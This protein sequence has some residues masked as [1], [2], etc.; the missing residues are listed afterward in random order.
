MAFPSGTV[1]GVDVSHYQ[2]VVDWPTL[3]TTGEAFAFAKA[4]EG[5]SIPDLYFADNW[6]AMRAAGILRGAYH[7]FHPA[8][9][10]ADQVSFFLDRLQNANGGSTQLAPGDLP[11]ALDLEVSDGVA[12]ADIIAGAGAWLVAIEAQTGRKPIV[13]TY[14]DFWKTTL[15]NPQ[16]LAGYPLWISQLNVNSPSIPGGWGNWIF[17]QFAKQPVTGISNGSVDVDAFNGSFAD[18]QTLAGVIPAAGVT[19]EAALSSAAKVKT[20]K[21]P[22]RRPKSTHPN[23]R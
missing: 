23:N 8:T 22:P 13:Y 14:V 7:F 5:K 6:A 2:E 18:L 10:A 21:R 3:A 9:A 16:D 17:W 4:S 19:A 11:A 12:A 1:P 15:G 20:P